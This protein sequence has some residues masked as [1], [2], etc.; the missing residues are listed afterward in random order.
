MLERGRS[1]QYSGLRSRVVD[2]S[3]GVG[4]CRG[5][6]AQRKVTF[7][8]DNLHLVA[9]VYFTRTPVDNRPVK[10]LL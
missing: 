8:L 4:Y 9:L 3:T 6:G 7:H 5:E 1:T 10:A 2:Q